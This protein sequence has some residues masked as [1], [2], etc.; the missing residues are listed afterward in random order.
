ML[1]YLIHTY[2][3]K[4]TTRKVNCLLQVLYVFA[5]LLD[6]PTDVLLRLLLFEHLQFSC[7][8]T[9]KCLIQTL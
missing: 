3:H 2:P 7:M 6:K 9:F 8:R 1:Y 4:C 5:H